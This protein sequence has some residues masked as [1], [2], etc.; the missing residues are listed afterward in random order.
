MTIRDERPARSEL[1]GRPTLIQRHGRANLPSTP[2]KIGDRR[3]PQRPNPP[4]GVPRQHSYD[5]AAHAP[6][7]SVSKDY[8]AARR[9][10]FFFPKQ[11]KSTTVLAKRSREE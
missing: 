4:D 1:A 10:Q 3:S 2:L 8:Q 9:D 7:P 5:W 11:R 6:Y